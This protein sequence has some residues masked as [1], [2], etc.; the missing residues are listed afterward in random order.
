[1]QLT[2]KIFDKNLFCTVADRPPVSVML[3]D[4]LVAELQACCD[5]YHDLQRSDDTAAL[6]AIGQTL[7]AVIN[8]QP[9]ETQLWLNATTGSRRLTVLA[10][11]NPTPEQQLLLHLPWE[12]LAENDKF[13]TADVVPFEVIRRV[14]EPSS[15]P[16]QPRYK[17]LTL[18]FMAADPGLKSGLNYEAEERAIF[19]ATRNHRNL[20]LLVDESGNLEELSRRLSEAGHCDVLHLSCHGSFD[21]ERGFVLQLEDEQFGPMTAT[22]HDFGRLRLHE[23][24]ST[25][26][27]SACHSANHQDKHSLMIDLARLGIANIVGWDGAVADEDATV[28]AEYF[29]QALQ[30]QATVPLACAIARQALLE[31]G[32]THWHLGRC[33]LSAQGG[34]ALVSRRK[35]KSQRRK[36]KPCHKLLDKEKQE[37]RVASRETFVGRR[38]QTKEALRVFWDR[39][40][41]GVLLYAIGGSGKSSLAARIADRLEPT[42]K[43][44]VLYRKYQ[45]FDVLQT[46]EAAARGAEKEVAFPKL[47]AQVQER[48]EQFK[49]ILIEQLE[50]VFGLFC[51]REA[52]GCASRR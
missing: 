17:D 38:R 24:F 6:L 30:R 40:Y 13:L 20:N 31:K 19:T 33:C 39:D 52:Q 7:F 11:A 43:A 4:A 10:E 36:G 51:L 28:F 32:Y 2:V 27:L 8:T 22:A 23:Q 15:A 25:L 1:M 14:G 47:I 50:G 45:P 44:A 3:T 49:N 41:A 48:P 5:Q 34:E 29:Y 21:A 9:A 18:A 42:F 16:L 26:F 37:V 46:L 12:I 35:P